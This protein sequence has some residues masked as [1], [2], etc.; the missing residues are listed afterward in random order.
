[1]AGV[2]LAPTRAIAAR[3]D[4][5]R[6]GLAALYVGMPAWLLMRIAGA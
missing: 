5:E 2:V 1:V 3:R 4:L 6:L